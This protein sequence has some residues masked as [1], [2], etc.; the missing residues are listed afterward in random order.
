[1]VRACDQMRSILHRPGPGRGRPAPSASSASSDAASGW[2]ARTGTLR[3]EPYRGQSL[4][5]D[6]GQCRRPGRSVCERRG[7]AAARRPPRQSSGDHQRRQPTPDLVLQYGRSARRAAGTVVALALRR[8]RHVHHRRAG[9]RGPPCRLAEQAPATAVADRETPEWVDVADLACR[10]S[11]GRRAVA[12]PG[13]SPRVARSRAARAAPASTRW[14]GRRG[15]CAPCR[16]AY[17]IQC[18]R[19][20]PGSPR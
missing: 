5:H 2:R 9:R 19:C 10:S 3:L 20:R 15:P 13:C 14:R 7:A 12:R 11:H 4:G 8:A 1:M 17:A 18:D 16:G 6:P